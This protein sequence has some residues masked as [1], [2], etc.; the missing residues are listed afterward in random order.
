M[1]FLS[2]YMCLFALAGTSF[3]NASTNR[4]HKIVSDD[5]FS[6]DTIT[7]C[8]SSPSGNY[9]AYSSL[10]WDKEADKRNADIWVFDTKSRTSQ[11]LTFDLAGDNNPQWGADD[12]WIYFTSA[13]EQGNA[14]IPPYNGTTQVWRI[15]VDGSR[16]MPVTRI[17]DGIHS[18]Q[19]SDNGR[20]LY[21]TTGKEVVEDEW[22]E[23]RGK[24]TIFLNT[25]TE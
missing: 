20:H 24:K 14:N 10:R 18:I 21:Y 13:R 8:V 25:G 12:R 6:I 7:N 5:Y 2:I 22:R 9:I 16:L 4:S 23:M 17:P 11:R 1:R 15:A 3:C 19:V